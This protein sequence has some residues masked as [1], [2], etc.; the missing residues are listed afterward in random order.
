MAGRIGTPLKISDLPAATTLDGSELVAVVQGDS[1]LD[2]TR[3]TTVNDIRL[4]SR[5]TTAERPTGL[6]S[7]HSF[8][9]FDTTLG[10]PV[11]WDG[12]SWVDAT[13]AAA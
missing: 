6:G 1:P 4:T 2:V 9:Y 3:R 5:G 10:K 7:D 8:T 12:D 13:G 11:F